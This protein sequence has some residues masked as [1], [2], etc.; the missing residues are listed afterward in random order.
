MVALSQAPHNLDGALDPDPTTGGQNDTAPSTPLNS[1]SCRIYC[2]NRKFNIL[3][4][5]WLRPR[6]LLCITE[7]ANPLTYF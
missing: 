4:R 6:L 2:K 5:L 1:F 3:M 7:S